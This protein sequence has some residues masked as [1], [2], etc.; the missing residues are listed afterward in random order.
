MKAVVPAM[1]CISA[2]TACGHEVSPHA[3]QELGFWPERPAATVQ[4]A[5]QLTAAL[6]AAKA[7][8]PADIQPPLVAL[9][10]A[11]PSPAESGADLARVPPGADAVSKAEVQ[12]AAEKTAATSEPLPVVRPADR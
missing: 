2:T 11:E 6:N 12:V 1:C 8:A 5:A 10:P 7:A 9:F 4:Q 3:P